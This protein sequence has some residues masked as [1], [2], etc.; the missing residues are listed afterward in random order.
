MFNRKPVTGPWGGGNSFLINMANYLKKQGHTVVYDFVYGIDLIFMIDPRPNQRGYSINDIYNYK[1][2]SPSVKILHRVNDTDIAR[3]TN[4]L[5]D[6]NIQSNKIVD[7]TVFISNWV[8]E[9]YE[10]RGMLI[11]NDTHSVIVNGCSTGW[12]YPKKEHLVGEKIKLITHHWSDNYMKG[13]DFYN[14]LDELCAKK[15]DIEFTYMG[16]YNKQYAPKNTN[17]IP[18]TSGPKMGDILR[19]HDIYVTAA[20]WEAC[21][22]HHIEGSACGLPVLYHRDGGAIPEICKSHGVE[23]YDYETFMGGLKHI[24]KNYIIFRNKINYEHLNIDRCMNQYT[25]VVECI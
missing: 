25:E 19:S 5:D 1:K 3:N 14:Y 4:I 13:F 22:M 9:Y 12:F 10:Q 21:G 17:L 15:S 8:K 7:Y 18:P 11:N 2:N 16:R 24:I 6:I 23:F 20:R